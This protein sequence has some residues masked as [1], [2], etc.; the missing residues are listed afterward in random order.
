MCI[1]WSNTFS[2]LISDYCYCFSVSLSLVF[3][4]FVIHSLNVEVCFTYKANPVTYN[5][6]LSKSA[7]STYNYSVIAD[8]HQSALNIHQMFTHC[9][10]LMMSTFCHFMYSQNAS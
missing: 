4:Q 7:T 3:M 9:K 8:T 10:T 6:K 2:L 5:P 1:I